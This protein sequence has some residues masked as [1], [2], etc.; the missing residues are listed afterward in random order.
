MKVYLAGGVH[1]LTGQQATE[2]RKEATKKL[3]AMDFKVIDPLRGRNLSDKGLISDSEDAIN[4]NSVVVRAK[5]DVN[6]ADIIL[7]EMMDTSRPYVGT[8]MEIYQAWQQDKPIITWS[9]YDNSFLKYHST[10]MFDNL[11]DCIDFIAAEYK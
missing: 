4:V 5:F 10:A 7:A 8:S 1:K 11:A 2:W 9:T 6:N 3:E